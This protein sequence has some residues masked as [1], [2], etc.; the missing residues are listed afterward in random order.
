MKL[1][2][3]I[4]MNDAVHFYQLVNYLCLHNVQEYLKNVLKNN[5]NA[6]QEWTT[7]MAC[8][9]DPPIMFFISGGCPNEHSFA[10]IW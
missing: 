8:R 7:L 10:I 6:W 3:D 1:E 2:K 9:Y 4:F 5:N